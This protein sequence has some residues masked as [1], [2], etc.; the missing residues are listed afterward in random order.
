MVNSASQALAE[1]KNQRMGGLLS[2]YSSTVNAAP[3]VGTSISDTAT[4]RLARS[5]PKKSTTAFMD[6]VRKRG[7]RMHQTALAGFQAKQQA[8]RQAMASGVGAG[9]GEAGHG[10]HSHGQPTSG[11][12]AP[13]AYDRTSKSGPYG[14][15]AFKGR[16]GLTV[17]A[18]N[19]FTKLEN[20]YRQVFGTGLQVGNGWRSVAQEAE[21]WNLYKAGKGPMASKP[22]TG[23]HGYGTAVDINGPI[24]NVNSR[25]HAWL[26][27]NAAQY[28]WFWVGQR[29]GEPWHWEFFPD[30]APR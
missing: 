27:Q 29:W 2:G 22:G 5:A 25:Q 14:Y 7:S 26:R 19:A 17:P 13:G 11:Y 4:E 24:N 12:R 16:Y 1:F 28:G 18:S 3:I 30:K 23:V 21:L 10:G 15:Q 6:Q 20:A 9:G 8:E